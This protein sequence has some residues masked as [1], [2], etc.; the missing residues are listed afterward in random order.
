MLNCRIW[1]HKEISYPY[2]WS[3]LSLLQWLLIFS[4]WFLSD[5]WKDDLSSSYIAV[6]HT[7]T[8]CMFLALP[9]NSMLLSWVVQQISCVALS[10]LLFRE[11]GTFFDFLFRLHHFISYSSSSFTNTNRSFVSSDRWL[12][13][14]TED[15]SLIGNHCFA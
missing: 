13:S 3:S 4:F 10:V 14:W 2:P 11:E 6:L 5:T 7:I 1:L 15:P 8:I 9:F 12:I